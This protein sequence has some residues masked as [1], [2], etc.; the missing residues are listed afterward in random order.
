MKIQS[1]NEPTFVCRPADTRWNPIL[2]IAM[3]V[4]TMGLA[5]PEASAE[6][7]V[8]LNA[9]SLTPG[10]LSEWTNTGTLGSSFLSAGTVI[11][12][13]VEVDG[14]KAVDFPE[15]TTN[16]AF[17]AGPAPSEAL[18]GNSRRT[19]EAWIYNPKVAGSEET[20]ISWGRRTATGINSALGHSSEANAGAAQFG[21]NGNNIGYGGKQVE[22][23]WTHVAV[24]YDPSAPIPVVR[25]YVDGNLASEETAGPLNTPSTDSLGVT[26][27][28]RIG[29]QTDNTGVVSATGIGSFSLARVRVYDAALTSAE[30]R[31]SALQD[32]LSIWPD[33]DND[34]LPN[35]YEDLYASN[36]IPE[37]P[38]LD[39]NNN[40]DA[41]LDPDGDGLTTLQEFNLGLNW[42]AADTDGDGVNDKTELDRLVSGNP[43]PT[44]PANPDTDGDGLKDGAEATAG[45]DPLI[46]D[47]DG[48]TY[49]DYAEVLAGSNPLDI[50]SI[51]SAETGPLVNLDA[52]NL[53]LGALASWTNTGSLGGQ[54]TPFSAAGNVTLLS[55]VKGLTN[56]ATSNA[57]VGPVPPP[58]I[59]G[60]ASRSVEAWVY[61]PAVGNEDT[62]F[63]WGRRGGPDGTNWAFCHGSRVEFGAFSNWGDS[64]NIGWGSPLKITANQ[65]EHVVGTYDGTDNS[66]KVYRNGVLANSKTVTAG[67]NTWKTD[68]RGELLKMVA[69]AQNV[70]TGL[71]LSNQGT[72]TMAKIKVYARTLT[73]LQIE[74]SFNDDKEIFLPTPPPNITSITYNSTTNEVAIQWSPTTVAA[75]R[76]IV[77]ETSTNLVSWVLTDVPLVGGS[78]TFQALDPANPGGPAGPKRFFRIRLQ[79]TSPEP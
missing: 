6:I 72:L 23:R 67:L 7:V 40:A 4:S 39:A 74:T 15:D 58:S 29:R 76:E 45:T 43:A 47:T 35:W 69:G 75:G 17:Y 49:N 28:I 12:Q 62:I 13:V 78:V 31:T 10:D 77:L 33:A 26:I 37:G 54:F 70:A 41:A 63:S 44:N 38:V 65:W 61:N 59:C 79:D 30:I 34:D 48:D 11:P 64:T 46:V 57:Y 66:L 18:L 27:P 1:T 56:T 3:A 42:N 32:G 2:S 73:A 14:V 22:E 52:T 53:P 24:V 5:L 19:M 55:G 20:I 50:N 60:N 36:P 51:P 25:S 8:D 71:T 21:G 16:T 68:T 9:T